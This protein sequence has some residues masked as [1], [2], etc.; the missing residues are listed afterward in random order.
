MAR[1][2]NLEHFLTDVATAIKTKKGDN[3]PIPAN[4]FDTEISNLGGVNIVNGIIEQYLAENETIDANT[5]V[6]FIN[7]MTTGTDTTLISISDAYPNAIAVLIDTDKVFIA[8]NDGNGYLN[9]IVC[10]ISGTTIT[11]GTDTSLSPY[12][13][14]SYQ[15]AS[16]VL[17]DTDKVFIAHRYGDYLAGIVC[18]ISG[19]T[20]T[21]GTDTTLVSSSNTY[22]YA[23]TVLIDTNKVF[24]A[25]NGNGSY[26]KG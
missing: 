7:N 23:S 9:G 17:I 1:T 11:A 10:T 20:I 19:T 12:G 2:D 13:G 18:T 21:A 25:H 14:N 4:T 24:I 6:E 3:T 5:F 15:Y 16:A 26:L 8:H 22:Q